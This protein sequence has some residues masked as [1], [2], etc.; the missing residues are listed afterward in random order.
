M[1]GDTSCGAG[2]G[3]AEGVGAGRRGAGIGGFD[4]G[5]ESGRG[6]AIV[7][8]GCFGYVVV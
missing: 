1:A 6:G 4:G 8:A 3:V 7:V 5:G 2:G